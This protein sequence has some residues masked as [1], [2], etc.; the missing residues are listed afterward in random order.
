MLLQ[1]EGEEGWRR[2]LAKM[3]FTQRAKVVP[4]LLWF[5]PCF[6]FASLL[7]ASS[8]ISA[9]ETLAPAGWCW[10]KHPTMVW[11]CARLSP[12]PCCIH[13]SQHRTPLL[14]LPYPC[15]IH[16]L[17][18]LQMLLDIFLTHFLWSPCNLLCRNNCNLFKCQ[19]ATRG[20]RQLCARAEQLQGTGPI[21]P[22]E[23]R[24]KLEER[25]RPFTRINWS[26]TPLLPKSLC[27]FI[28]FLWG[29]HLVKELGYKTSSSFCF[30]STEVSAQSRGI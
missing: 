20:R 13:Y 18:T 29:Y 26:L 11:G 10:A 24:S 27:S 5:L 6:P 12:A 8:I 22:L 17:N 30:Y 14:I 23:Q 3:V 9:L 1:K 7:S 2:T 15:Y 28:P 19:Q 25:K 16:V 4:S 21:L